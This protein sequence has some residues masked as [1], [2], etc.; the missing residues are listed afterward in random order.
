MFKTLLTRL[1]AKKISLSVRGYVNAASKFEPIQFAAVFKS[2]TFA[3]NPCGEVYVTREIWLHFWRSY[4]G[5]ILTYRRAPDGSWTWL[6][7]NRIYD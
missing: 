3:Q 6:K 1:T 2:P 7:D 4:F 5:I